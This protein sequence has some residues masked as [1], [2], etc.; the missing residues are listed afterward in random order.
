[1]S[2]QRA[3]FAPFAVVLARPLDI[4]VPV[5]L[6][7]GAEDRLFCGP[8]LFGTVCSSA[9]ALIAAEAVQPPLGT[10]LPRLSLQEGMAEGLGL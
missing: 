8:T 7:N 2:G 1:M 4:R 10:P 6:V 5:L 9:E 3:W